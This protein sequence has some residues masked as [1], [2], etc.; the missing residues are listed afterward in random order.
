MTTPCR[1]DDRYPRS[2]CV[3]QLEL[4]AEVRIDRCAVCGEYSLFQRRGKRN[5]RTF[6]FTSLA[7]AKAA[8]E[9]IR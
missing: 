5:Q 8:A 2:L 4:D 1:T 9:R 7:D 6:G 3:W